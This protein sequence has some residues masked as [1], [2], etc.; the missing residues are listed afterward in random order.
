MFYDICPN[1]FESVHS[2][3]CPNCGY[4]QISAKKYNDV[5]LPMTILNAKYLVGRVLGKGGFGVTYLAKDLESEKL[6]AI[7]EC[8]PEH[9]SYRAGDYSV[10]HKDSNTFAFN[11]CKLNFRDEVNALYDLRNNPFVVDVLDYFSENNTEY[12]AMEYIDGVSLKVLTHSQ[13]GKVS[14]ESAVL[15]LF[16]AGSALMEVHGKGIIH[17]DISPENIMIAKNGDIKLIDFGSAKNYLK[18]QTTEN[19]AIFLKHGFA[20]PEQYQFDGYQGPWTDVY[21]LA[22]TFYTIISAQPLVESRHRL[23]YDSMRTLAELGCDVP[24]YV[25]TAV[26]RALA[27]EINYRYQSVGAFLDDMAALASSVNGM[28][29]GTLDVIRAE[30]ERENV[31]GVV[32]KETSELPYVEVLTGKSR[33][34]KIQIPEYG[35]VT[36]GRSQETANLV[37]DD[38]SELSRSHCLVSYDSARNVF[39]VVDISMN[40]TYYSNHQRMIKDADSY[41]EPNS[42]F[43]LYASDLRLRVRLG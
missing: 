6:V 5:L 14:F 19:G 28:D 30:K 21:A 35:S 34:Q 38:Y 24:Y 27:T 15:V 43:Y 41:L 37:V 8:M 29:A 42:E 2:E 4:N 18:S 7:K 33:G 17:R 26:E 3:T 23:E 10:Q 11:Q 13:G 40:G 25:S 9:Y 36:I 16:S 31:A 12:F 39:C 1:C 20:P 32:S 22:A